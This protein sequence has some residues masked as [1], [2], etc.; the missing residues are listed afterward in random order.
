MMPTAC[1]ASI[2]ASPVSA[3]SR[4]LTH[5]E[6]Q[7][8]ELEERAIEIRCRTILLPGGSTSFKVPASLGW[9]GFLKLPF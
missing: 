1:R 9:R 8:P 2:G 6:A 7:R 3:G 5:A 4:P